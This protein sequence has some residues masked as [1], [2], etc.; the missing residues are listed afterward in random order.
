MIELELIDG[1]C[2]AED[3]AVV[4]MLSV[5]VY[6]TAPGTDEVCNLKKRCVDVLQPPQ[7][8]DDITELLRDQERQPLIDTQ[9]EGAATINIVARTEAGSCFKGE[10]YPVCGVGDIGA[11]SDDGVLEINMRCDGC[12]DEAPKP[13]P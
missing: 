12:S 6:G 1:G 8:V 11:R 2:T 10:T 4:K 5:D 13:C 9:L 3:L 7:S